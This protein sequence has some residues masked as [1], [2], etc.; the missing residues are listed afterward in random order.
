MFFQ[1]EF[2]NDSLCPS[3]LFQARIKKIMQTDEEIGK[4]AAAVPVIICILFFFFAE[5]SEFI[6]LF[7]VSVFG[8]LCEFVCVCV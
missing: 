5:V 1:V 3:F 4:V 8:M 6:C 7:V 2:Q